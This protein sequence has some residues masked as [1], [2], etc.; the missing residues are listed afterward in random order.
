MEIKTSSTPHPIPGLLR[1]CLKDIF[2]RRL[3]VTFSPRPACYST[4]FRSVF[5]TF[6]C[7]T[8]AQVCLHVRTRETLCST[9]L[10]PPIVR[11]ASI[12]ASTMSWTVRFSKMAHSRSE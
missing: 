10:K 7:G 8:E 6:I 11:K 3:P 9:A 2:Q 4:D 12:R 1:R 5:M